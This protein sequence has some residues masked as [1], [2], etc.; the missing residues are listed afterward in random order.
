MEDLSTKTAT[1][2]VSSS[3]TYS[4]GLL[5]IPSVTVPYGIGGTFFYDAQLELVPFI[6]PLTFE[7]K[8]TAKLRG[9]HPSM[10]N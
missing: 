1:P 7:L 2:S 5:H 6:E 8:N 10:G 4:N 9:N 3:A